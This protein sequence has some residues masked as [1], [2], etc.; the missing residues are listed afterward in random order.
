MRTRTHSIR[1]PH[2]LKTAAAP[3]LKKF[4]ENGQEVIR[5]MKWNGNGGTWSEPTPEQRAAGVFYPSF[6]HYRK[7]HEGEQL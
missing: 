7:A 3:Y 1:L 6:Q 2:R 4:Q 5:V